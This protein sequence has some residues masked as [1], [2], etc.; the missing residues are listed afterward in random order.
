MLDLI[1][2][3]TT[4][5]DNAVKHGDEIYSKHGNPSDVSLY[6]K[7][8]K[9]ERVPLT[10]S[11]PVRAYDDRMEFDIMTDRPVDGY[12]AL[13]NRATDALL[14]VRPVS[15]H[16]A[17]IPHDTLFGKQAA[18]LAESPLP[19]DNVSVV[20][21]IYGNGKRVHRTVMFNDLNTETRT[22]TGQIDLVKCRMD[23]FN[24]V[25][26]SW[27]FQVFSGAYRDLCRNSLVF[28]GQKSYHQRKIHK[29]H[30]DVDAMMKKAEVGLDMWTNQRD[31]MEVWQ[32]SH[33]SEFDLLRML[34]ATICRKN[35][36]AAKLDE[37]LA[38]NER[39]LNWLLERFKE[40]TPEL[41]STLW[42]AYNA[43]THYST[44]LPNIQAR[45]SNRELVA[46]RRADEVRTVIESDFWRGL[47]RKV[48]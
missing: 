37:N 35:T 40:E 9:V 1:E 30:I 42:A 31:Q 33:C 8:A 12:S 43:L 2:Q 7:Y 38:I 48:A 28:G 11:T 32:N 29:G 4:A 25:D 20:D 16:Y 3:E 41:G 45:N 23:I 6:S 34:K 22:R 24:S 15:R 13:Y 18:L 19:T 44:H 5:I 26:L 27:A 47:E 36:R 39:K 10:A 17:L 46:T 21:R 14:D